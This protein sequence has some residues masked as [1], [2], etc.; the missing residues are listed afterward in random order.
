MDE[1]QLQHI[2]KRFYKVD[3]A[4]TVKSGV[5]IGLSIVK[6]IMDMHETPID[7][8]SQPGKGT[9]FTFLLPLSKEYDE[10]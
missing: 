3:K 8:K 4:R 6:S 7:V 2:W 1:D 10:K 9:T 5:G